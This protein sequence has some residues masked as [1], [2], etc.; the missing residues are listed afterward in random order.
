[1]NQFTFWRNWLLGL[2]VFLVVFGIA[3]AFLNQTPLF[4]ILFNNQ[5]DP[6]FFPEGGI[7]PQILAFQQ[8]VYGV[9]G[10]TVLG[11]GIFIVFIV[12][13]PFRIGERWVWNCLA[14][15]VT[16][17][18][19]IDTAISVYFRVIFNAVFNILLFILVLLPLIFT[20]RY[21]RKNGKGV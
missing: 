20:W 12:Y 3:T 11:W 18:F 1:M 10:A 7:T 13:Y 14:A 5:I 21:F 8:W 15:G 19:I 17:W 9:L 4:D 6:I 16:S 2:G